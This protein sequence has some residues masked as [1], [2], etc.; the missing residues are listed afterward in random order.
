MRLLTLSFF[1]MLS[2]LCLA[3][4][5]RENN[6]I[7]HINT[8]LNFDTSPAQ[9]LTFPTYLTQFLDSSSACIS[10]KDGKLVLFADAGYLYDMKRLR[11]IYDY[12]FTNTSKIFIPFQN[13]DKY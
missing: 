12:N 13:E 1:C 4:R 11:R 6:W 5:V 2:T 9:L 3:Q 10:Y 8:W 7:T